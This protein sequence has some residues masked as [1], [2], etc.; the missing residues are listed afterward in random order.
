M[1]LFPRT[2]GYNSATW[3]ATLDI[4]SSNT[5]LVLKEP[6]G[7]REGSGRKDATGELQVRRAEWWGKRLPSQGETVKD[8]ARLDA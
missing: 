7:P 6:S 8:N 3:E 5:I 1:S 2:H 4:K